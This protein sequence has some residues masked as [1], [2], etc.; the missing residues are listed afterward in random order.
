VT[1]FSSPFWIPFKASLSS[2]ILGNSIMLKHSS[3]TP[4]CSLAIQR[5][6]NDAGFDRGEYQNVFLDIN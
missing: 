1:P 5:L 3:T 6:F 2:I 4:L